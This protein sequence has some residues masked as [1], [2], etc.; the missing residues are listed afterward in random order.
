MICSD[1]FLPPFTKLNRNSVDNI[2]RHEWIQDTATANVNRISTKKKIKLVLTVFSL[3]CKRF[4]VETHSSVEFDRRFD[5]LSEFFYSVSKQRVVALSTPVER[6]KTGNR[7]TALPFHLTILNRLTWMDKGTQISFKI[8]TATR[9][10]YNGV[11]C[12][13]WHNSAKFR[14]EIKRRDDLIFFSYFSL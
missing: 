8:N 2:E 13:W 9:H 1:L 4:N 11:S 6:I 14:N 10:R 12:F 3:K 5:V 7:S